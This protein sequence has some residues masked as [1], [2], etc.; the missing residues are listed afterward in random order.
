VGGSHSFAWGSFLGSSYAHERRLYLR[1]AV[2]DARSCLRSLIECLIWAEE[3]MARLKEGSDLTSECL[4]GGWIS[5]SVLERCGKVAIVLI[6][7]G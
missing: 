3:Q 4:N 7:K 6:F 5:A 1:A 2:C